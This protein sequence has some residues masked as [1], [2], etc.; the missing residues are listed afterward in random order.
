MRSYAVDRAARDG[1]CQ[2]VKETR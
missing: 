2:E 1:I